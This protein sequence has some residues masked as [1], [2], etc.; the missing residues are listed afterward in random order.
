MQ[1]ADHLDR[2]RTAAIENFGDAGATPEKRFKIAASQ[3][4]AFH[5]IE[6]RVDRIGGGWVRAATRSG[7]QEW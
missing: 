3:A 1:L 2:E 5:V 4:T 7:R 6:Q